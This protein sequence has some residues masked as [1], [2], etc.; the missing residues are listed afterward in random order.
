MR[1]TN[2]AGL[3]GLTACAALLGACA[4]GT[5]GLGLTSVASYGASNA[6]SPSGYSEKQIDDTHYQVTATG[7]E[8]TPKD[9][10]EKIARARAA[11]IA[12]EKRMKFYKVA[13]V[14]YGISCTKGHEFYKGGCPRAC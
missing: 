1:W 4:S 8:A 10:I 3:A 13:N 11:Q 2:F 5:G 9:R 12:V 7:T 6:L 14:Q